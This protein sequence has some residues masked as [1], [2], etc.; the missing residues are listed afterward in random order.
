MT[1]AFKQ[2]F[3]IQILNQYWADQKDDNTDDLCSHGE[4]H[5]TINEV[6]VITEHDGEWTLSTSALQLL[7]SV[8]S[9]FQGQDTSMILHCGML[10]MMGCPISVSWDV[11]HTQDAVR[12]NNVYKI[13]TVRGNTERF[14]EAEVELKLVEY[15]RPI[16]KF[17]DEVYDFFNRSEEEKVSKG[18]EDREF[19]QFWQEF[20]EKRQRARRLF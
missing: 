6:D 20:S 4:I 2:Q 18:Y 13:P 19:A 8:F 1:I 14:G 12:I 16:I 10:L 17:A 5:L 3:D 15:A 9:D 7:R 11:T